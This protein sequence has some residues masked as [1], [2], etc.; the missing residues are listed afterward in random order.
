[1][2]DFYW[3]GATD[4]L[5][6]K[7]QNW[8]LS[9]GG[10]A[11]GAWPGG[12]PGASDNFLFD[13]KSSVT[14]DWESSVVS[15]ATVRSIKCSLTAPF[16][17]VIRPTINITLQGLILNCEL[18]TVG[19]GTPVLTFSGTPLTELQDSGGR[20]R[21]I[22]NGQLAN[23]DNFLNGTYKINNNATYNYL[24]NGPYPKLQLTNNVMALQYNEPTATTHDHADDDTIHIKGNFITDTGFGRENPPD[25]KHD[26]LVNI[27]F[28]T[29]S[30]TITCSSMDF[31]MATAFFR[32]SEIPVTGSTTYGTVANGFTAR[33]YA[34]VV[35]ASTPGETST[36]KNGLALN[37]YSFEVKGRCYL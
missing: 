4:S 37:C 18:R 30:L 10:T 22:L 19:A 23:I 5:A 6:S 27:K 20:E 31:V 13:D 24:D 12:S 3:I 36:M 28:D 17:G 33:H 2:T 25:M 16:T 14:C 34:V 8:S 26:T 1:M 15:M 29:T 35:F 32:G 7:Y 9:S 11:L 21:Y